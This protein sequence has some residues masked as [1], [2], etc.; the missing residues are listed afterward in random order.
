[1]EYD[2]MFLTSCTGNRSFACR[3]KQKTIRCCKKKWGPSNVY[4]CVLEALQN[5]AEDTP[6]RW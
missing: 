4:K 1:M 5:L 3:Q 2:V 6:D